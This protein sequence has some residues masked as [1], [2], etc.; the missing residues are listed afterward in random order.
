MFPEGFSKTYSSMSSRITHR[1]NKGI[2]LRRIVVI[3]I[4]HVNMMH[5]RVYIGIA[6]GRMGSSSERQSAWQ[7]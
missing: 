2:A 4:G 7:S 3:T 5:M 1:H 6:S